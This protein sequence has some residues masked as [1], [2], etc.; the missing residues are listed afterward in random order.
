VVADFTQLELLLGATI[1]ERETGM[2]SEMLN[3]FRR[4][5]DLHTETAAWVLGKDTSAVTK[6]ERNLAKGITSACFSAAAARRSRRRP[7][8]TAWRSASLRPRSTARPSSRSTRNSKSGTER[9]KRTLGGA[10]G[11]PRHP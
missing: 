6:E 8:S 3:V 2:T 1:A 4:G 10:S 7:P 9:S 11:R 5:D